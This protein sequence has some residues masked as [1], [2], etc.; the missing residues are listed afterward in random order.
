MQ[1]SKILII[2]DE[3]EILQLIDAIISC[4]DYEIELLSDSTKAISF[5][6]KSKPDLILLDVN[7]PEVNGF[8]LCK[9][10]KERGELKDIPV[11]F[12]TGLNDVKHV[13]KGFEV[14]AVDYIA[15]PVKAEELI[16]RVKTHLELKGYRDKLED[17]IAEKLEEINSQKRLLEQKNS[18]LLEV[19]DQ[20]SAEKDRQKESFRLNLSNSV[21]P[22]MAKLKTVLS[23]D[24]EDLYNLLESSINSCADSYGIKVNEKFSSLS[25]KEREICLMIKN[26][27]TSKEIAEMLAISIDTVSTHRK[28]IRKK[29]GLDNQDKSLSRYLFEME[30]E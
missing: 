23:R 10:L 18:A 7:M 3:F 25:T 6:E 16:A 27:M 21:M 12:L 29:L 22:I 1:K 2:D 30:S 28:R 14:G 5:I 19:L 8:I 4:D 9:K 17:I 24:N 26:G 15:K 13:S 20:Y 11:I